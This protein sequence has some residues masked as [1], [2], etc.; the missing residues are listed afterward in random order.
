MS[1][2]QSVLAVSQHQIQELERHLDAF[3]GIRDRAV[4]AIPEI[5]NQIEATVRG[6]SE[7]S[8]KITTAMRTAAD[9][10]Q[11]HATGFVENLEVLR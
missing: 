10:L 8:S 9:S 4:E 3:G 5:Q 6:A 2:L 11:E 7:A 1:A